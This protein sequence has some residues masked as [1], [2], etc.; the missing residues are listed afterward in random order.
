MKRLIIVLIAA[1]LL[2]TPS[3]KF[4]ESIN[5]FGRKARATEALQKQQEA[6]RVADS[7]KVAAQKVEEEKARQAELERVA[8]E[9]QARLA[10]ELTSQYHI[11]VGSFLN[12]AYAASWSDHCREM[13]YDT[14]IIEWNDGR[15]NLVSAKSFGTLSGA[16][17][18]LPAFMASFDMQ[19]WV[20]TGR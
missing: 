16:Y 18:E 13:G 8:A 15:W 11:I 9:E 19:A 7:I 10:A 6:F 5:P 17:N 3:C 14:K 1:L 4:I 12:R 2:L 20:L